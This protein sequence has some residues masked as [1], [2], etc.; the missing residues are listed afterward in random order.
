[1]NFKIS[2][3]I[4]VNY[5]ILFLAIIYSCSSEVNINSI[6]KNQLDKETSLYLKQHSEN[7]INWQR[8]SNSIFDVS[9][10][11]DKLLVISIGYSSCHWCHVMEEETFTNDSIAKTM[12]DNFINIKVDREE[13]PDVDQAYMTASQLMTGMGGWPLNVITLPDGSPIYAGTYHTT[14]QWNDILKRIIRLKNDN[15]GGLKDIASNVKNGVIDINTIKKQEEVTEFNSEFLKNNI[16]IW[17]EKWDLSFGGDLA[18]QKFVS[19]SKY[20]FLLN[21]GR[22]YNDDNVLEHV[23]NTIDIIASSGLNDFI[24]G[25]FY[26]YTIDSEW[27]TPHFEKM[28]YDQAQMI[29]LYSLAYK[30]Y[31][32]E[33]YK[34]VI[35]QTISFLNSKMSS[36][37]GLYFAAMDADTD[38]EEGKY[39]SYTLEE[40]KMISENTDQKLFNSYYNIDQAN[41][42]ENNRFLLLPNKYN[43]EDKWLESNNISKT[44]L[45]SLNNIWEKNIIQLKEKR[46][47]PRIDDKI[48]ISW[49]SLAVIGLIDAYEALKNKEYLEIAIS[50]FNELKDNSFKKNKLIHTYKKNQFQEGVL[51]D[52]AYL[53]KATMRL[54]QATGNESYFDFSKRITDE[55]LQLFND[56]KSDLLKYSN[57]DELFTKVISIDDGVMPSPNSIIAEQLFNIGHIIF[58]DEYLDLSDKMV[59]SVQKIIDENINSY[60]V[61]GNNIL[62]RVESFYEIAVIGPNAKSL[63]DQITR[64]FTPNTIVVQS[65]DESKIPLFIDRYFDDE[66]FIYVCQNKTCQRPETNINL[67]LEQVPY[68]N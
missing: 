1:M 29:S 6:N 35:D 58:D 37:N 46:T 38:G 11:L 44:D 12:N 30:V 25:G 45:S 60:S 48:I 8:W 31:G 62:N 2:K 68:I 19:P 66:T 57:N 7:P 47:K 14:S 36:E 64:Y 41:P 4:N 18:Q 49:N 39:Y 13:N 51:E 20:L 33:S 42:W 9:Q 59:S 15:Y 22:I 28:L 52:Y 55:A 27:K 17:K 43:Y 24:E 54:F 67:A 53:S 40:L 34:E 16:N 56:D 65:D 5:Y 61:W 32:D 63:T 50:M 23:K 3:L 10:E 21:Y 26:R